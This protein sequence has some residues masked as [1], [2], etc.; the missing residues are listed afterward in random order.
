MQYREGKYMLNLRRVDLNLLTVFEVI[1][2]ERN[3]TRAS[4]RVGMS[5]P[6]MS[7]ALN[8]LRH[9]F[10]D[11]LFVRQGNSM[12]PTPKA[13]QVSRQVNTALA[14][15]RECIGE[16]EVF[17][18]S[19]GRTFNIAGVES[20]D[21]FVLPKLIASF[22]ELIDRIHINTFKGF[23][24]ENINRLKSGDIDLL[25]E[26]SVYRDDEIHLL[27][28]TNVKLVCIASK[29]HPLA[30]QKLTLEQFKSLHHVVLQAADKHGLHMEQ[31]LLEWGKGN[32]IVARTPHTYSMPIICAE[33]NVVC[34]VP[35]ILANMFK[36]QYDLVVL[37]IPVTLPSF[38]V[39][40][41]WHQSQDN[42]SGNRWLREK[43]IAAYKAL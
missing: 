24:E 30:G 31:Q 10:E 32:N 9:L 19:V 43:V 27:P 28:L 7:N 33:S 41:L 36:N 18:P 25:I 29:H 1:F 8:R 3:L 39:S 5:Q 17:D 26:H 42:D 11:D 6:A 37:D 20:L 12:Q 23:D 21:I 34:V 40:V 16:T 15:I 35:E 38:Q 13:Q 22:G 4:S 2:S 14:A